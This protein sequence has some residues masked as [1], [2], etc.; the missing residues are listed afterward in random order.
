[1][2]RHSEN[3]GDAIEHQV[4]EE[5]VQ[6]I[7]VIDYCAIRLSGEYAVGMCGIFCSGSVRM[8]QELALAKI[9]Y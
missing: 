5:N 1:M 6:R 4:V 2:F 9:D 3:F 7:P 8:D